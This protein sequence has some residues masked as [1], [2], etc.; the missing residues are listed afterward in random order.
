MFERTP[1]PSWLN[2]AGIESA[3]RAP[4]IQ[5]I[6]SMTDVQEDE[7]LLALLH[8]LRDDGSLENKSLENKLLREALPGHA[9]RGRVGRVCVLGLRGLRVTKRG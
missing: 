7:R 9:H 3:L 4:E 2:S 8:H 5:K 6:L 1:W